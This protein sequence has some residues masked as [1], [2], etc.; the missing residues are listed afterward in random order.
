M[1]LKFLVFFASSLRNVGENQTK[2]GLKYWVYRTV[3]SNGVKRKSDQGGIEIEIC[4]FLVGELQ[5][6]ENQTKVG[7][8]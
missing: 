3:K 4:W 1:G 6:R 2:V 8:K 7:L 5:V